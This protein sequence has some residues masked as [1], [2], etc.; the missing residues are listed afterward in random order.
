M[1]IQALIFLAGLI[2]LYFGAEW[3]IKGAASLALQYGIR[4][5][6]VG[7][8]V[9]A[10]GTSMPEFIINFFAALSN[11]DGLALGNIVGSNIC[12]VAMILGLSALMMPLAVAP[13]VL[14]REY[15]I[16]LAVMVLFYVLAL[17]GRIGKLDGLLLLAGLGGFFFYLLVDTRQQKRRPA[18]VEEAADEPAV[19]APAVKAPPRWHKVGVLVLG[20]A[21]LAVGAKLMVQAAVTVAHTMGVS[22][23]VIGLTVVAVG[24]SLPELAASVVSALRR[25]ADISI[26]NILGS[27]LLNVL[28]VVGLVS[29]IRPLDV[30]TEALQLHFPVMIAFSLLLLPF[31]W[32]RNTI[33][34]WEGGVMLAGFAG[35]VVYIVLPYV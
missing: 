13:S 27:N 9:V 18:E 8:T 31:A 1:L 17:D 16:M 32:S 26:G 7:I 29:V 25:E 34:R 19:E 6:V 28:F 21:G 20:I 2:L 30:E 12:N 14:R 23:V 4:P 11:Q 5:M 22:P 33:S 24:T 15:P 35:Y 3:L 10:L